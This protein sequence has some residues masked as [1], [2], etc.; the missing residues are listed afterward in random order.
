MCINSYTLYLFK[1]IVSGGLE[2]GDYGMDPF[3]VPAPPPAT[4]DSCE[5]AFSY[6]TINGDPQVGATTES[7]DADWY[8]FE[9]DVDY[10]NVSVSLCES[11]FDTKLEVWG[12]CDDA[13]YLGYNDDFCGLQSQVDLTD[14]AAGTYHARC[15]VTAVLLVITY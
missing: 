15:M 1:T 3:S 5:D 10:D 6:G 7:G 8:S 4:G 9:V 2:S 12:A 11:G 14:V 13:A